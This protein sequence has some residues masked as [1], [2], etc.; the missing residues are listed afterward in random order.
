MEARRS[1]P[2]R[3]RNGDVN[4]ARKHRRDGEAHRGRTPARA[5]RC[6]VLLVDVASARHHEPRALRERV[7]SSARRREAWSR[8]DRG[9]GRM[10]LRALCLAQAGAARRAVERGR[11]RRCLS[12]RVRNASDAGQA[13]SRVPSPVAAPGFC[14]HTSRIVDVKQQSARGVCS[15]VSIGATQTRQSARGPSWAR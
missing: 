12:R 10:A 15:I 2:A 7:S 4:D 1:E 3:E 13:M 9:R 14:G 8:V 5:R 11:S 6:A